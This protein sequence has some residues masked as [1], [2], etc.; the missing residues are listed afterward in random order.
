MSTQI[1]FTQAG[2]MLPTPI[3]CSIESEHQYRLGLLE[4]PGVLI[5]GARQVH[6]RVGHR[7]VVADAPRQGERDLVD[8]AL[9]HHPRVEHPLGHRLRRSIRCA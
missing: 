8:H 1:V 3:E 5:L 6:D 7:A 4:Q 2:I 9:V